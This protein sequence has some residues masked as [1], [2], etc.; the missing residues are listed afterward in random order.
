VRLATTANRPTLRAQDIGVMYMDTTLAAAG[1][2]IWW[3][4]TNWVDATGAT[5]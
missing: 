3:N 2:P 5:V 4:G 1:K